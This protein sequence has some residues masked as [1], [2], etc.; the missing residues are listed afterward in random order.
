MHQA[1]AVVVSVG[2][3]HIIV[4]FSYGDFPI[5]GIPP[6]GNS[7]NVP[8][9]IQNIEQKTISNVFISTNYYQYI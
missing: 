1:T 9:I 6:E 3:E 5:V 8:I 7:A 4:E 2:I